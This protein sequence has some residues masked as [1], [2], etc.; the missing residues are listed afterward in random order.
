[1]EHNEIQAKKNSIEIKW[2]WQVATTGLNKEGGGLKTEMTSERLCY[3][4]L[5]LAALL[6]LTFQVQD[7]TS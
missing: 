1:M 2:Q 5:I 6:M 3:T 4:F 7:S